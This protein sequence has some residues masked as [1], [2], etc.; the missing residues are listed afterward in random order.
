MLNSSSEQRSVLPCPGSARR[1]C[2]N[3]NSKVAELIGKILP[4]D[5][6]N[7]FWKFSPILASRSTSTSVIQSP[8]LDRSLTVENYIHFYYHTPFQSSVVQSQWFLAYANLFYLLP[9]LNND[10]FGVILQN[11]FYQMISPI[12]GCTLTWKKL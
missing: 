8:N 9:W 2:L 7:S 6:S 4:N 3:P 1:L 12:D 5:L 10:F 11:K